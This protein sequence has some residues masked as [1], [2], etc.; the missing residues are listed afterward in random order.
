[1]NGKTGAP[2]KIKFVSHPKSVHKSG[3]PSIKN[4]PEADFMKNLFAYGK[5]RQF[6]QPTQLECDIVC[7]EKPVIKL[8]F[9]GGVEYDLCQK[10][11][12]KWEG[13]QSK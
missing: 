2:R 6:A 3:R 1:M 4:S 12:E 8:M 7:R 5:P 9:G 13:K 11:A 10:H